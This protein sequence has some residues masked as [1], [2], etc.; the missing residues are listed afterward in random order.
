MKQ[1]ITSSLGSIPKEIDH[2]KCKQVVRS[3]FFLCPVPESVKLHTS[4]IWGGMIASREEL[5]YST[6]ADIVGFVKIFLEDL[7][8][9][10]GLSFTLVNNMGFNHI[11]PDI[12]VVTDGQRLVG[13]IEVKKRGPGILIEPTNCSTRCCSWKAS[14]ALALC[15]AS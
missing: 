7:I 10:M 6:E 2:A 1:T 5:S 3:D 12:C 4:R 13:V 8:V 15:W 9:A 11:V 14:T